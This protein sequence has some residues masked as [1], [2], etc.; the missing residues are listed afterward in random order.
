MNHPDVIKIERITMPSKHLSWEWSKEIIY[1][2]DGF[3]LIREI[4]NGSKKR[5]TYKRDDS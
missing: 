5:L 3:I 4:L 2:N 1:F